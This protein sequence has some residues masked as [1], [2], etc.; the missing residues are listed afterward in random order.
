MRPTNH[1]FYSY[2]AKY[3]DEN[4]AELL[5]PA[6]ISQELQEEVRDIR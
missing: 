2:A 1:E 6:A 3:V 5:I 4:G